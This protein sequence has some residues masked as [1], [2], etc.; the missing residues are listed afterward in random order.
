MNICTAAKKPISFTLSV[1][2]SVCQSICISATP[3]EQISVKFNIG[4]F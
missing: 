1:C 3:N 2:P 4:N